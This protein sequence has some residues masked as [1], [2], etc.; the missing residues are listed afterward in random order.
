MRGILGSVGFVS[1]L[2]AAGQAF[3]A[4]ECPKASL[5]DRIGGSAFIFS[6]RPVISVP[7]PPGSSPFHSEQS[8][9]AP[10]AG[11]NDLVTLFRVDTMWKGEARKMIRVRHEQGEC[12]AVFK[13]DVPA[14]IFATSD[15]N[16]VLWTWHCSG[17]AVDGDSAY[18]GL[19]ESLT[20][21]LHYN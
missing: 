16:G 5:D 4:C 20:N 7:I 18:Q 15:G 6:G 19:K 12:G 3:A 21:R 8:L 11:Q 1:L 9:E 17:D 14:I 13:T 2:L 10:R